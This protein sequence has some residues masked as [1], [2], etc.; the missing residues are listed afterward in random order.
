MAVCA[1]GAFHSCSKDDGI[2]AGDAEA[3]K[4]VLF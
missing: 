3:G 4:H 2:K 1:A